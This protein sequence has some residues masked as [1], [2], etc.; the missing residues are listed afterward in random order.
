[1]TSSPKDQG[2]F[3]G[4]SWNPEQY[5]KFAD[6]RSRPGWDLLNRIADCSP[7]VIYDL[8]CGTGRLTR[9]LAERWPAAQVI[10]VDHSP[11]ML[12][13]A[14]EG[15]G[16]IE[17][18]R[19]DLQDWLPD[20]RPD[21][22]YANASLH[23]VTDHATVFPRLL[24]SLNPGGCLAVQMPL[25]WALPSHRL[26]RETLVDGGPGG[27]PLGP[28]ELRQAVARNWVGTAAGYHE[29]LAGLTDSLEIWE[30]EYLQVLAGDDPVLAWVRSTGLRP[31][32]N[33]LDQQER[34]LFL[35]A[36]AQRLR[37]AYPVRKDGR[38]LFPFRR[39]FLVARVR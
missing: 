3:A 32:L 18:R 2:A 34:D 21:L 5:N 6:S 4:S 12:A 35:A 27:R 28:P 13:A 7:A 19:A 29:M 1:M 33:S 37:A 20:E 24:N 30:T 36:Y 15:G 17:W 26:M 25:S 14:A 38:T 8:G 9:A 16:P 39:L 11:E 22:L 10:G 31:I 23:W